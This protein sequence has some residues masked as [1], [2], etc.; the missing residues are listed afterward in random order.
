[1]CDD[2]SDTM[3]DANSVNLSGMMSVL[4]PGQCGQWCF[5][6]AKAGSWEHLGP[7]AATHFMSEAT[8]FVLFH[9]HIILHVY[10]SRHL[11]G[12]VHPTSC[13]VPVY[14]LTSCVRHSSLWDWF[15]GAVF[16]GNVYRA[17]T[18]PTT[19]S[20]FASPPSAS[21]LLATAWPLAAA[22]ICSFWIDLSVLKNCD[23]SSV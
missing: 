22:T 11:D 17:Q 23:T 19:Q 1:M 3:W 20:L 7:S 9:W 18:H 4:G 8:C 10:V 21:I 12:M 14:R 16:R 5:E 13:R 2:V 6:K 15:P